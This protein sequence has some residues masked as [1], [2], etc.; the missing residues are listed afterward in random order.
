MSLK[1]SSNVRAIE[2]GCNILDF[3]SKGKRSYSIR[4]ISNQLTLPKPTIHRIL[5]TFCNLGYATQDPVS[6]D[7][8]LS[9]RFVELG[10]AVLDRI[11]LR[12]EAETFLHQLADRVQE[13]VHLANLDN[14]EIVYL[15]KIERIVEPLGLRMASKIG[16]R[17]FAHSCAL[18][19]VLLA[20]LPDKERNK[21]LEQKGLPKRTKNTIVD[22]KVLTEHLAIIKS[23]GYAVD[24]EENEE[25]IRCVAAPIRN[26]RGEVTAGIS[27]SGPAVRITKERI[28]R[29]LKSEV[30]KAAAKISKQLGYEN[31]AAG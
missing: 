4:D 23:Q 10:Q 22:L 13:T 21:I 30:M 27:I 26:Y 17:N 29:Q 5:S 2:K 14:G 9:F 31:P 15:D 11:D 7:Y 16:M 28:N 8:R 12:K 6:K 18:G 19:K 20:F 1:K 3:L 25:G 24:N